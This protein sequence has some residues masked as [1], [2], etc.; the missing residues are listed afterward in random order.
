MFLGS[1]KVHGEDSG[2]RPFVETD[3]L[4]PEDV[5]GRSKLEAEQALGEIAARRAMEL[6]V[7]RPPLVYGPGVKANFLRLVK[8]VDSGWPI[9]LAGVANRRSLIYLG[10]LVDAVIRCA[11]HPDARGPFLVGD[12]ESVSTAEL[13]SRIA[14]ALQRPARLVS[15]PPALLRLAGYATGRGDEVRRLTGNLAV[16]ASR[17]HKVLDWSPPF[18]LDRGLAE[19][20][21]WFR[22]VRR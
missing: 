16:D 12:E 20:A 17:A 18:T 10:N 3:P 6:A 15:V 2:S 11:E 19:T 1:V 13:V 14:R 9:P 4:R 5:Y 22:S 21:R 7:I 8:W